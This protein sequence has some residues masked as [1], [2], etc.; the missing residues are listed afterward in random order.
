MFEGR[1]WTF[2]GARPASPPLRA[3]A[4]P[5]SGV[6]AG[7]RVAV[8]AETCAEVIVAL[9]GHY[10]LGAIHVPINTRYR[11]EEAAH[12]LEDSG[13]K[14]VLPPG[15]RA[16]PCSAGIV[17]RGPVSTAF[18]IWIGAAISARPGDLVFDRFSRRARPP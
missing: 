10:R 1:T 16:G 11:A 12:I 18:R 8:F 5:P 6:E 14:A 2:G 17:A 9:L 7:D 3:G 15:E 13:A 4:F